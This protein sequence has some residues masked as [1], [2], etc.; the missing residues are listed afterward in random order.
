MTPIRL[1]I[2]SD[3]EKIQSLLWKDGDM[4]RQEDLYDLQ[5]MVADLALKVAEHEGKVEQLV[6]KFPY[7]YEKA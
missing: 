7:L 2:Y 1:R 6:K 4:I 5:E 3:I